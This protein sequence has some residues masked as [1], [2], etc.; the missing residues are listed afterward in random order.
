MKNIFRFFILFSFILFMSLYL[1]VGLGFYKPYVRKYSLTD[2]A[3]KRYDNDIK[4]GKKIDTSNYVIEDSNYNN[5]LSY[6]ALALSNFIGKSFRN[7]LNKLLR[8]AASISN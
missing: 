1:S 6:S 3:I 7:I 5:L 2:D 4:N 8:D